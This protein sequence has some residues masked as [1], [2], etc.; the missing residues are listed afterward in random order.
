MLS[1]DISV[2]DSLVSSKAAVSDSMASSDAADTGPIVSS[3]TGGGR[4]AMNP[5][6]QKQ[7][8]AKKELVVEVVE[9]IPAV[10]IEDDAVPLAAVPDNGVENS[11]RYVIPV[12]LGFLLAAAYLVPRSKYN[13]Q[14][15]QMRE[16]AYRNEGRV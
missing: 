7:P 9:D 13:R 16:E 11:V 12:C 2:T 5:E 3:D 10:E 15:F 4:G 14:L 1:S 8:A 6:E